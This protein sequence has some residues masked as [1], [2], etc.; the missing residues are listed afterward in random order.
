MLLT[1]SL[2]ALTLFA[3]PKPACVAPTETGIFRITTE[4]K[5]RGSM[6]VG[7]L[8]LENIDDCLVVSMLTEEAG[9]A[10][11][12]RVQ[13]NDGMLT[14]EVKLRSGTAKVALHVSTRDVKGSIVEG[15]R[16]WTVAGTRTS[17]G[18]RRV[19]AVDDRR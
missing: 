12:D 14:G 15:K 10:A 8:L 6:K 1:S 3:N 9:P 19:A 2:L 11:V 16:E 7:M 13:L 5:D 17:G 18:E 4:T